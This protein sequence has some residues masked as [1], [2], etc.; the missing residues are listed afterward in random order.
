[1]WS[2]FGLLAS[3]ELREAS[4]RVLWILVA[5]PFVLDDLHSVFS[6][7]PPRYQ[8]VS[9]WIHCKRHSLNRH[10]RSCNDNKSNCQSLTWQRH[11]VYSFILQWFHKLLVFRSNKVDCNTRSA[12]KESFSHQP[13]FN[14]VSTYQNVLYVPHDAYM[15]L[16]HADTQCW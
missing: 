16:C 12:W 13:S 11:D 2:W 7:S 3:L 10:M 8:R 15:C 9:S 1:M 14:A 6:A 4:Y 5:C